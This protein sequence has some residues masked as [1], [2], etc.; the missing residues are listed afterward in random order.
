MDFANALEQKTGAAKRLLFN[1]SSVAAD[2]YG[3]MFLTASE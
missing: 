2:D 1:G 3:G